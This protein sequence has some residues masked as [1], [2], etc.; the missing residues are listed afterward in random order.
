[1]SVNIRIAKAA[2]LPEI[3]RLIADD[4][5]GRQRENFNLPLDR[6]YVEAFNEID[7]DANNELIVAELE[8]AI[9]GT[10]QMTVTPSLSFRG[11]RRCT[12]ESVRVDEHLRSKGIGR[13]L[14]LFAIGRARELGCRSVQLTSHATRE[15]AHRFYERLGFAA[16]HLGMKLIL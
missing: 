15:R 7:A 13:E 1:M 5:L 8:G 14:M 11:S 9:V 4:Y 10:M 16:S 6:R 2:D 3:V 12:I